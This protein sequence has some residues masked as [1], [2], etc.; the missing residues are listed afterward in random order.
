MFGESPAGDAERVERGVDGEDMTL[1]VN[2]CSYWWLFVIAGSIEL[3]DKFSDFQVRLK[4]RW[5]PGSRA[6]NPNAMR[7]P[8][9]ARPH[10]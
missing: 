4:L 5:T 10:T 9:V 2:Y 6:H 8:R 7:V 1:I 3:D